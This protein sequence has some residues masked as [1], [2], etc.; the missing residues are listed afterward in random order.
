[1][2]IGE[3]RVKFQQCYADYL[4]SLAE[5]GEWTAEIGFANNGYIGDSGVEV[6]TEMHMLTDGGFTIRASGEAASFIEFGTGVLA[7][8]VRSGVQADYE[9]RPGSWSEG[10]AQMFSRYG[11]WYYKGERLDSAPPACG[12]QDACA[13]MEQQSSDIARRAFA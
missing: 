3:Y 12:M 8:A 13:A 4:Q 6:S 5:L 7:G 9:I 11:Y 1:M 2:T 10:H